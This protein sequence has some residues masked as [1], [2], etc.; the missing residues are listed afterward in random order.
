MRVYAAVVVVATAFLGLWL[1]NTPLIL[2]PDIALAGLF[3]GQTPVVHSS[4][5][6]GLWFAV[7]GFGVL[8]VSTFAIVHFSR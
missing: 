5:V 1:V 2:T 8:I 4:F 3:H 6:A 7:A